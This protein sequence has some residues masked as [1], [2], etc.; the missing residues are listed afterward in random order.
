[1]KKSPAKKTQMSKKNSDQSDS[2]SSVEESADWKVREKELNIKVLLVSEQT[3]TKLEAEI[4]A[5]HCTSL[6]TCRVGV[7]ILEG[8]EF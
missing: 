3:L 8:I 2:E 5:K 7:D 1:M 6:T 4:L